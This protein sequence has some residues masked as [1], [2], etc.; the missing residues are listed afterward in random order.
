MKKLSSLLII[1]SMMLAVSG[2]SAY[3]STVTRSIPSARVTI[4]TGNIDF[5][6]TEMD[7]PLSF[8]TVPENQYYTLSDAF[9]AEENTTILPGSTPRIRVL[10]EAI[11]KETAH[12][13]YDLIYLFRGSYT[14]NNVSVTKGTLEKAEVKDSGYFLELTIKVDGLSGKFDMVSS[15]DWTEPLGTA[16]WVQNE[17]DS[18]FH[19]IICYRGSSTVKKLTNYRGTSYNFYPYMTKSGS[20]KFKIRTVQDP[21]TKNG[22][23][24]E[25]QESGE[26]YIEED[27]VS[28]GS[29]QTTAD[30]NGGGS[31]TPVMSSGS[32]QYPNGTGNSVVVGWVEQNGYTY[33]VYPNG[34]YAKSG[35]VKMD[36]KWYM[37][38][39]AGHRLTGWQKNKYG[40]WFYMDPATAV[41][42]TGWLKDNGNWYFLDTTA[43]DS[44]G[45]MITGWLTWNNQKYYFNSS[46]VMVTGWYKIDDSY[47]YFYP[48]GSTD[49]AYGFMARNT[50]VGDF[51]FDENGIWK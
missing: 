47:R 19:D 31:S 18:G 16:S 26:L 14:S 45:H 40:K 42:K 22:K 46:G 12:S 28:D 20:Y 30:E 25:W 39:E 13:N 29:G 23:P 2:F 11:P 38:D 24:S 17:I 5:T 15:A 10:L 36:G 48:E 1:L 37:F 43:G 4:V 49:G 9:W 7:S 33:F 35:W 21:N 44:E 34:E 6:N 3:A 32:N 50:K 51:T 41:M 27:Q 8:I